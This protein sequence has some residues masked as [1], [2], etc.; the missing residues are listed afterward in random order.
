MEEIKVLPSIP[1]NFE[2]SKR[3]FVI[4]P[5][6]SITHEEIADAYQLLYRFEHEEEIKPNSVVGTRR[7]L[8]LVDRLGSM[9]P[10]HR[11][12]EEFCRAI[13]QLGKHPYVS[14]YYYHNLPIEG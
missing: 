8:L 7:T 12:T 6:V 10:F 2:L 5:P 13:Q 1:S 11:I 3:S 9:S 14:I 4:I